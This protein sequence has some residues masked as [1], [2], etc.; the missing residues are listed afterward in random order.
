MGEVPAPG[1][2]IVLGL[3]ETVVP[4]GIPEADRAM[5]LLKPPLTAVVVVE[6]PALPSATLREVGDAEIVKLGPLVTVKVTVVLCRI[7]PPLPVTV[8]G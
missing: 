1:A 7:P 8:M 2:G 3:K 4:E 6:I 5:A